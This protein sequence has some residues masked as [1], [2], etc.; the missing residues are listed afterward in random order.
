MS[1]LK[2]SLTTNKTNK[3]LRKKLVSPFIS[4]LLSQRSLSFY[5][6]A[7]LGYQQNWDTLR[8]EALRCDALRCDV[9]R[10]KKKVG[11]SAELLSQKSFFIKRYKNFFKFSIPVLREPALYE[12]ETLSRRKNKNTLNHNV[13]RPMQVKPAS[14]SPYS[15][16]GLVK[17]KSKFFIICEES[18]IETNRCFY[19]CFYL[20][21]FDPGQSLTVANALR[22]TLLSELTGMAI[23]AVE[24]EGALH[25]YSNL[26]GVRDSVL[27]ILLNL[28]E[29]VLKKVNVPFKKNNK[30]I[31]FKP[32]S[33]DTVSHFKR[34]L[35]EFSKKEQG[36]TLPIEEGKTTNLK[37]LKTQVGYLRARGPGIVKAADLKLPPFLQCVDPEQYIATLSEDGCLN[38]K[39]FINEGKNYNLNT[40]SKN[41]DLTEI[42]KRR[43]LIKKLLKNN[44]TNIINR[45]PVVASESS[46][47]NLDLSSK[48][49]LLGG[50]SAS[51][52]RTIP[53][54]VETQ[55]NSPS[56]KT[57]FSSSNILEIDALFMPVTK[58]NY[59]IESSEQFNDILGSNNLDVFVPAQFLNNKEDKKKKK[60]VVNHF[61]K[62]ES[63]FGLC[64]KGLGSRIAKIKTK[65]MNGNLLNKTPFIIKK[66]KTAQTKIDFKHN[67]ILEIW[68][69]GSINPK[70]ALFFSLKNLLN[71]FGSLNKVKFMGSF[72][73]SH[74]SY[75]KILNFSTLKKSTKFFKVSRVNF[76][77]F[78]VEKLGVYPRYA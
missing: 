48:A 44:K 30:K 11:I 17:K 60:L 49:S 55:K 26:L 72:Y 46:S 41:L 47:L 62:S 66:P 28:K 54:I 15:Q 71:V 14:S 69:N 59:I 8:C 42:K 38:M 2:F 57:I 24:I 10:D 74:Q 4:H 65:K 5:I 76:K 36:S 56:Y 7:K 35:N 68:T 32:N 29:I 20:G 77:K 37:L 6:P 33:Q 63:P 52:T 64:P 18:R 70:Q 53:S 78:K 61:F 9:K 16:A 40:P 1:F 43:F 31:K 67:V 21:P 12:T 23:T 13:A 25:E 19:G 34:S 50:T 73:K 51:D 58:V 45:S 27:D 3:K 22:R 75:R 39:L